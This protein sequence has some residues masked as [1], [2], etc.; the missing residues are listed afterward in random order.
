MMIRRLWQ[1][2]AAALRCGL[3]SIAALLAIGCGATGGPGTEKVRRDVVVTVTYKGTP[4]IAGRID[5]QNHATGDAGG[6]EIDAS[7][8]ATI[9]GLPVG[10]Y[11]VAILAPSVVVVPGVNDN[12]RISE[13]PDIPQ[14]YRSL[15]TS[16]L[17]AKI[18]EQNYKMTFELEDE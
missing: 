13:P 5:F 7:G 9:P 10:D 6:G 12:E 16:P 15:T 17:K 3:W 11:S 2:N 14:K 1:R 8:Q 18:S 4:V